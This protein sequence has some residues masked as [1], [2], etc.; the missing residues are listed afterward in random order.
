MSML[1]TPKHLYISNPPKPWSGAA[2]PQALH[3]AP[4]ANLWVLITAAMMSWAV[5][6]LGLVA[7]WAGLGLPR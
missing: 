1:D 7:V 2:P 4:R 5:T 6:F 3:F